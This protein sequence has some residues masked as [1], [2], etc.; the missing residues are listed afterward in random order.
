[1]WFKCHLLNYIPLNFRC[2]WYNQR[3]KETLCKKRDAAE[4]SSTEIQSIAGVM[5]EAI[6]DT[7]L[8]PYGTVR[9]DLRIRR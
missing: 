9:I 6:H 1:M 5:E 3:Q 8:L 2:E 4:N 7:L